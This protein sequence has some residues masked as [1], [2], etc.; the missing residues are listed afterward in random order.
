MSYKTTILQ[1]LDQIITDSSSDFITIGKLLKYLEKEATF[2]LL[3]ILSLPFLQPIPLP[4]L[5]TIFGLL[6]AIL[7]I[8][9]MFNLTIPY[10]KRLTHIKLPKTI[11]HKIL[12][13]LHIILTK[14]EYIFKPRLPNIAGHVAVQF[15][16]GFLILISSACLA[17]PLPPG[18]NFPPALV[19]FI[20]SYGLL[21]K[22]IFLIILGMMVFSLEA[23]MVF[24]LLSWISLLMKNLVLYF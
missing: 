12:T 13:T 4:G 9:L 16:A 5:S 21:E 10:P 19:C 7:S 17:L 18:T 15:L 3:L 20:L 22:D 8:S 6:M 24:Y 11:I 14:T 23:T 1:T 2:L